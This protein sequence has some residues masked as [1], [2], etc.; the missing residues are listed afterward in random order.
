MAPRGGGDVRARLWGLLALVLALLLPARRVAQGRA[1]LCLWKGGTLTRVRIPTRYMSKPFQGLLYLPPCYAEHRQATYPLLILLHGQHYTPYQWDT[2]GL[3]ELLDNLIPSGVLPPVVV[4]MPWEQNWEHPDETPFDEALM[5]DA[6]PWL[7]ANY[8]LR[9]GRKYRAIGGVS[10][11]AAWAIR[12]GLSRWDRFAALGAHSPAVFAGDGWWLPRWLKAIP[13]GQWPRIYID[14][15]DADFYE[16]QF[17]ARLLAQWLARYQIPYE[18][19]YNVG[20]HNNAYWQR[21]LRYYIRWYVQP[22]QK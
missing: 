14:V 22:W 18:W 2:L 10:R 21:H 19:H 9:P 6:L 15:G 7:E 17:S 20:R 8:R 5:E 13:Q 11:G 3:D 12:L 1:E 4:F 16:I